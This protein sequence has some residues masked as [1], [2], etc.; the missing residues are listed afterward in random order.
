MG[1][2]LQ[3]E[4]HDNRG[5]DEV[6]YGFVYFN[7]N[8][9]VSYAAHPD[10]AGG[11]RVTGGT[12]GWSPITRTH[13]RLATNYLIEQGVLQP[14]PARPTKREIYPDSFDRIQREDE[15]GLE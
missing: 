7:D 13:V 3:V 6:P 12:G 4:S 9:R 10:T 2:V 14:P 1:F 15:Q 11:P 8:K 5:T